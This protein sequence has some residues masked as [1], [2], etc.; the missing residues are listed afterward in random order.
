M[1]GQPHVDSSQVMLPHPKTL[2]SDG[3]LSPPLHHGLSPKLPSEHDAELLR[4]VAADTPSHRGAWTPTSKAWQ[5]FTRRHDSKENLGRS[6]IPEEGEEPE[7]TDFTV[8]RPTKVT[9][10]QLTDDGTCSLLL[11]Y[12]FLLT[13]HRLCYQC[14]PTRRL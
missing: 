2:T 10:D 7:G 11:H 14:F 5:T 9:V 1:R 8:E 4:L 13:M 6:Q 3:S 12:R